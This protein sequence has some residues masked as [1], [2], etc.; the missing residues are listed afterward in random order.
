M[1]TG[2][3]LEPAAPV[4]IAGTLPMRIWP[5]TRMA[6]ATANPTRELVF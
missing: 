4:T 5:V 3:G 2:A 6:D 1:F